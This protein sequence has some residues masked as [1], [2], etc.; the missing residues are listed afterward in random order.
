MAELDPGAL[1]IGRSMRPVLQVEVGDEVLPASLM[2]SQS[3][4][5]TVEGGDGDRRLLSELFGR[6]VNNSRQRPEFGQPGL[7]CLVGRRDHIVASKYKGRTTNEPNDCR[8]AGKD[9]CIDA[10]SNQQQAESG[11]Q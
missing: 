10:N 5:E 11:C 7:L 8:C 3:V 4:A 2:R 6:G 9:K 1:G